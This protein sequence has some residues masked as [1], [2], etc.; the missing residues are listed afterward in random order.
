MY[1]L[2][3]V[4][5]EQILRQ[6]LCR[7]IDWNSLGF[8]VADEAANGEE[9]LIKIKR[10]APDVVVTDIRMPVMDGL[11]LLEIAFERYPEV[12]FVILSGFEEFDYAKRALKMGALDYVSSSRWIPIYRACLHALK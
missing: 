12:K 4:D 3:I 5:D 9:A 8:E 10:S 7:T 1:R 2:L 6:G 11:T